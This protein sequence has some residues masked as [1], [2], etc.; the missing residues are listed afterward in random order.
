MHISEYITE[1]KLLPHADLATAWDSIVAADQ[2]KDRLLN[3]AVLSIRLRSELPFETTSL[4]GLILLHGVPG[5]GKTTLARAVGQEL[6]PLVGGQTRL[7]EVN[8]HGLMSAEHGQSQQRVF[9]LM[10]DHVPDLAGA[11]MPTVLVLDE[12]ESMAVARSAASLSANPA[13]VHRA[14][15]ALLMALDRNARSHPNLIVVATSNFTSALDEAFVSRADVTIEMP[16]PDRAAAS[17][18]LVRTLSD[19]GARYPKLGALAANAP[20]VAG[21]LAGMDGRRIRK[22]VTEALAARRETVL[23]PDALRLEDLMTAASRLKHTDSSE[24]HRAAA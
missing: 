20:R 10:C 17:A 18:I 7:V 16:P 22:V 6:A 19:F 14:T 24:A 3:Q 21:E 15:D 2:V 11:D 13:D 1:N 8:P 4:H 9:E 5:T 12:V 23:D